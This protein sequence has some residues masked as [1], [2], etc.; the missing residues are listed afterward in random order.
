[1]LPP[2]V[3][4]RVERIDLLRG[5]R[6]FIEDWVVTEV[7]VLLYVNGEHIATF[8]SL[9][10]QLKELCIGWLL[11]QSL[12][13]SIDEIEEV[14]VRE[15]KVHV[16]CSRSVKAR[17]K[18]LRLVAFMDSACGSE[19][20]QGFQLIDR[21]FKPFVNSKYCV[22]ATDILGFIKVLN[23]NSRLFK[24][25][26]GAHAAMLFDNGK[27]AAFA[28]DV[29]RHNAVDKVVGAAAMSRVEFSHSVLVSTGRQPANMVLKA[30][31]VGI[32]I[33]VSL[34]APLY[35]G[36]V[37]AEKTGVTLVCFARGKRMNVYSHHE[38][39]KEDLMER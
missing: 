32:P 21:V 34:A 3:K 35:S 28:E 27:V 10:L 18:A 29:G 38:R 36:I 15:E 4:V 26:G 19:V 31:R 5:K 6:E 7:P 16:R 9:P 2:S 25:T 13:D 39:I 24:L 23:E 37:M 1:M 11:T 14:N 22:K 12:V 20:G 17:I 30:A 8:M 33:V